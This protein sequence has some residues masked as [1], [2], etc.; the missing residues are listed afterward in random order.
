MTETYETLFNFHNDDFEVYKNDNS[1]GTDRYYLFVEGYLAF[2]TLDEV[3]NLYNDFLKE[4]NSYLSRMSFEKTAKTPINSFYRTREIAVNYE[5]GYYE[6]FLDTHIT[7]DIWDLYYYMEDVIKQLNDL[8]NDIK[9][10]K[11]TPKVEGESNE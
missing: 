7:H 1:H 10:G 4:F 2:R 3:V 11:V 9:S 8:D 6:V 5:H